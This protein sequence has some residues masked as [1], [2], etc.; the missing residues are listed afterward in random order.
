MPVIEESIM[1]KNS[2]G[3]IYTI[4]ISGVFYTVYLVY[5]YQKYL[6]D[7]VDEISSDYDNNSQKTNQKLLIEKDIEVI[8]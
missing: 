1:V 7:D 6:K 5:S 3:A 2:V 4:A 8:S